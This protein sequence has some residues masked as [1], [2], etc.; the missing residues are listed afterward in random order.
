MN[1]VF[2]RSTVVILGHLFFR[3]TAAAIQIAEIQ[4]RS[5]VFLLLQVNKTLCNRGVRSWLFWHTQLWS[6]SLL[7]AGGLLLLKSI[8]KRALQRMLHL[9]CQSVCFALLQGSRWVALHS[10]LRAF[11]DARFFEKLHS[12]TASKYALR[13]VEQ[14]NQTLLFW[15]GYQYNA[16]F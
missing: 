6:F 4:K 1:I 3:H 15:L 10:G 2:R 13:Q 11:V 16:F 9:Y 5:S 14:Q 8:W 12:Y 7:G